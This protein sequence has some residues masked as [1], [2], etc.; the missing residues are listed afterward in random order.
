MKLPLEDVETRPASDMGALRKGKINRTFVTRNQKAVFLIFASKRNKNFFT[1]INP[2]L[3]ALP[4]LAGQRGLHHAVILP[5]SPGLVNKLDV[6]DSRRGDAVGPQGV[7][8]WLLGG[9]LRV[10]DVENDVAFAHVKVPG[11]N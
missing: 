3:H 2:H 9:S 5:Q 11:D 8:A 7:F 10:V 6:V 4:L 1:M